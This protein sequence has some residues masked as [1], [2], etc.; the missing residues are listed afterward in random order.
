VRA[1]VIA[2][3]PDRPPG[4][5]GP[6]RRATDAARRWL[7][8]G[9]AR[10]RQTRAVLATLLLAAGAIAALRAGLPEQPQ[11]G[12]AVWAGAPAPPYDTLPGRT[13]IPAPSL[14]SEDGQVVEGTVPVRPL[15]GHEQ[16]QGRR[17][18]GLVLGRYCRDPAALTI[19]FPYGAAGPTYV[20]VVSDRRTGRFVATIALSP[21]GSEED[22]SYEWRGWLD[23]LHRCR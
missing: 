15:W 11:P 5:L 12:Q 19:A 2:S 9:T 17:A 10:Q 3:E 20:A 4:R 23:Q 7:A 8:T 1:D 21:T 16:E 22:G 6:R 18:V 13:P 14:V